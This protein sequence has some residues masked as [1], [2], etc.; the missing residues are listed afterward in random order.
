MLAAHA[1]YGLHVEASVKTE[2]CES[3]AE[4]G[5]ENGIPALSRSRV[6]A[7]ALECL[8]HVAAVHVKPAIARSVRL[9]AEPAGGTEP[10]GQDGEFVLAESLD[11]VRVRVEDEVAEEARPA[12]SVW[13]C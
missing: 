13:C 1:G 8:G 6:P 3:A 9:R 10:D 5:A 11:V 12:H 2:A 4:R 7:V